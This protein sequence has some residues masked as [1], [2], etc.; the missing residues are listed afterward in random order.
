MNEQHA[1]DAMVSLGHVD[2]LRAFRLLMRHLPDGLRAGELAEALG[3]S[4]SALT[5][6]LGVLKRAKLVRARRSQRSIIYSPAL[7]QMHAVL[8]FLMNDCCQGNPEVCGFVG[9][10]SN[11]VA[12][13]H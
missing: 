12:G 2:R 4:P 11:K 9:Q 13:D 3:I 5:F 10:I 8:E 1:V 7:D 6:H